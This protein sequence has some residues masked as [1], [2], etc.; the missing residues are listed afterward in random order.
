MPYPFEPS[1][2]MP[3]AV[4]TH[5]RQRS[6]VS[7]LA[8]LPPVSPAS[9]VEDSPPACATY[10]E[11]TGDVTLPPSPPLMAWDLDA[12]IK[13]L[14]G[15][16]WK[17]PAPR[18]LSTTLAEKAPL[19]WRTPPKGGAYV[20]AKSL[21]ATLV[22]G[23]ASLCLTIVIL[24]AL[25]SAYVPPDDLGGTRI[26]SLLESF[27][28]ETDQR[29]SQ[30]ASSR[31]STPQAQRLRVILMQ[32]RAS[33]KSTCRIRTRIAGDPTTRNANRRIS[34]PDCASSTS[35][36]NAKRLLRPSSTGCAARRS[37]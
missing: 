37:S 9:S 3:F 26:R 2:I 22:L 10:D 28:T 33:C 18:L 23:V 24:C 16:E 8:Q 35:G 7:R 11:R 4:P 17:R 19:M 21:R 27:W 25:P 20:P 29:K 32:P 5:L 1:R 31:A 6:S 15:G 14:N 12:S 36:T 30:P 13:K 34:S